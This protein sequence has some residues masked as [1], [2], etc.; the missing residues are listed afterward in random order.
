MLDA[1][2]RLLELRRHRAAADLLLAFI[3]RRPD[4]L[5]AHLLLTDA[6][7]ALGRDDIADEKLRLV[8]ILANISSNDQAARAVASAESAVSA[9]RSSAALVGAA[10]LQSAAPMRTA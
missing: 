1:A 3:N 10:T 9:S 5:D 2:R 4:A 7:R 6:I 8:G